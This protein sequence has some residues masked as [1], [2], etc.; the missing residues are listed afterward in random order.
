[1]KMKLQRAP[2]AL[3]GIV[4]GAIWFLLAIAFM[5]YNTPTAKNEVPIPFSPLVPQ[6]FRVDGVVTADWLQFIF[7]FILFLTWY[8]IYRVVRLNDQ[9]HTLQ[10]VLR[11]VVPIWVFAITIVFIATFWTPIIGLNGL[12]VVE[13]SLVTL[14]LLVFTVLFV[15]AFRLY[16]EIL[17]Y[18]SRQGKVFRII[19]RFT[20]LCASFY[21]IWHLQFTVQGAPILKN[22]FLFG[23]L[24]QDAWVVPFWPSWLIGMALVSLSLLIIRK[25][26]INIQY[27]EKTM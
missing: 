26:A 20:L 11:A 12:S 17:R 15:G 3:Q 24:S 13:R 6:M 2:I 8:A 9:T 1:M 5:L 14:G 21:V 19:C 4:L 25:K 10:P 18:S 23:G 22:T 7:W 16:G 27:R